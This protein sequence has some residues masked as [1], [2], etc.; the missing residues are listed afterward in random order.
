MNLEELYNTVSFA[1][2]R[3]NSYGGSLPADQI[4]LVIPVKVIGTAGPLPS[5]KV[6]H[7]SMGMDWNKGKILVT[8]EVNLRICDQDEIVELKERYEELALSVSE[9]A[10]LK[11]DNEKLRKTIVKLKDKLE[12]FTKKDEEI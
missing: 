4:E 3:V 6:K 5:V 2:D 9:V 11:R 12:K 7:L 8:P 1:Y 10:S